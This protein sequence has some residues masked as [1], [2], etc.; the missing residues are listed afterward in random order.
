MYDLNFI[1]IQ[2]DAMMPHWIVTPDVT[3]LTY[4]L[5][6][7]D[8]ILLSDHRQAGKTTV[9]NAVAARLIGMS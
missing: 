1:R 5:Q 3:T 8:Y 9:A 2:P 7:G 4:L 6:S